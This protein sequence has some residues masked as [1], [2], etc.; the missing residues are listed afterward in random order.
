M[1]G[2]VVSH[3][4]IVE[5]LGGG[6]MGVVYGADDL[7]LGRR[8]AMKFLPPE[9]SLDPHAIERFEREARAASA[10]NHPHICTIHDFGEESG[11]HFLVMELLEGK[12]LK[13]LIGER[14]LQMDRVLSL[15]VQ[16]ADA[17]DAAHAKG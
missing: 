4:R 1:I 8:V 2:R 10:L 7:R 17:L 3:Y 12:T 6:G 9:F 11:Q 15:A 5:A 13:H 16:I 14:P